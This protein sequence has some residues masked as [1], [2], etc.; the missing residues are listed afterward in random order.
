MNA[1][2]A[3][4]GVAGLRT[5]TRDEVARLNGL[6]DRPRARLPGATGYGSMIGL[7]LRE[8]QRTLLH[9]HMLERGYS[10]ARR[11]FIGLSLPLTEADVDGSADA[12][13]ELPLP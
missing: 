3:A 9:L 1:P 7:H 11:G 10:D 5:S 8:E 12:A 2:F 13:V 6:G 4:T